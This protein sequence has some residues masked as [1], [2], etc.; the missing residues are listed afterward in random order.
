MLHVGLWIVATFLIVAFVAPQI[1]G[2]ARREARIR[3]GDPPT[4]LTFRGLQPARKG[5]YLRWGISSLL[6]KTPEG[7][8]QLERTLRIV[9]RV[10]LFGAA[11]ALIGTL[12][13]VVV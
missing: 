9:G 10:A 5:G 6:I 4:A 3:E 13:A 12:A 8:R 11:I 2:M 1:R 7:W